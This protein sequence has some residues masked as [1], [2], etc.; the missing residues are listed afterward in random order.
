MKINPATERAMAEAAERIRMQNKQMEI[1]RMEEIVRQEKLRLE[2]LRPF[3]RDKGNN[4][5][6]LA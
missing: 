3:D 1:K 4:V 5:D 2:R 6:T